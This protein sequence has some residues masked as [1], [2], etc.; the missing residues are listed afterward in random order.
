MRSLLQ[1]SKFYLLN[2]YLLNLFF[3]VIEKIIE[4]G[5]GRVL[6]F[7]PAGNA[8]TSAEKHFFFIDFFFIQHFCREAYYY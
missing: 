8:F 2:I 6:P 4:G 1:G 3:F 5:E 7:P